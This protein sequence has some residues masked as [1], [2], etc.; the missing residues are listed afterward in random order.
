MS[1]DDDVNLV[2]FPVTLISSQ[3]ILSELLNESLRHAQR[4]PLRLSLI[5]KFLSKFGAIGQAEAVV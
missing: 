5:S 1:I 2:K 3:Y 4:V